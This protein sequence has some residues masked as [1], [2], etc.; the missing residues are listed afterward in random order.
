MP[1][2]ILYV[3]LGIITGFASGCFGIGGGAIMVPILILFFK[4]PYH[5]AIGTSLALIIPISL[6]GGFKNFQIG[7]IDWNIFYAAAIAGIVGALVGVS[8][9]Q[10]VPAEYARKGFAVFLL[11]T[12][13]RLWV[14]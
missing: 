6:A 8:L 13:Y 9:I 4:V 14:K 10:K 3:L 2:W 1:D 11:F 7:K 5:T 12:A